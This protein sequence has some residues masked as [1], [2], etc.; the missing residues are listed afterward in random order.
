MRKKYIVHKKN[1]THTL[2]N[3]YKRKK[4]QKYMFNFIYK[5]LIAKTTS[6][7]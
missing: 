1:Q 6:D 5:N 4:I 2:Q 7:Y 3:I